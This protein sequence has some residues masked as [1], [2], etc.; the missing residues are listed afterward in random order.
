MFDFLFNPLAQAQRVLKKVES[1]I[2]QEEALLHSQ[3]KLT[4]VESYN[5]DIRNALEKARQLLFKE[6]K[7]YQAPSRRLQRKIGYEVC[8]AKYHR[9]IQATMVLDEIAQLLAEIEKEVSGEKMVLEKIGDSS[10]TN[11]WLKDLDLKY[12]QMFVD[13]QLLEQELLGREINEKIAAKAVPRNVAESYLW[14]GALLTKEHQ[15]L[16]LANACRYKIINGEKHSIV[17]DRQG[18][19]ITEIP[20]HKELD[21][22]TSRKIM[23]A[24]A[25]GHFIGRKSA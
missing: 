20:H 8:I 2:L 24:M 22:V 5:R 12:R 23:R 7:K 18:N 15:L 9:T 1:L 16:K 25:E 10:F 17:L 4:S 14:Q 21:G 11:E 19:K 13:I 3:P 6:A